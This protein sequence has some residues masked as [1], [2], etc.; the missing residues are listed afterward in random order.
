MTTYRVVVERTRVDRMEIEVTGQILQHAS[1]RAQRFVDGD[2]RQRAVR[3][4]RT[5]EDDPNPTEIVE[6]VSVREVR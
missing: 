1:S 4:A 3:V 2:R 5:Y 6:V